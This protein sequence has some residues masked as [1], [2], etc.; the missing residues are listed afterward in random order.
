MT[1]LSCTRPWSQS[2][3]AGTD[4][5]AAK[6]ASIA[7][8]TEVA[9][10]SLFG[11]IRYVLL[12]KFYSIPYVPESAASMGKEKIYNLSSKDGR[13][14]LYVRRRRKRCLG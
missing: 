14:G 12:V 7:I 6:P 3:Q 10:R 13:S 8:I 2:S 11:D 5:I 4:D 1:L 9:Q